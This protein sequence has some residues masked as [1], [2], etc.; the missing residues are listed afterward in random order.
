[1]LEIGCGCGRSALPMA[2][3]LTSGRYT[4]ID[5]SKE[6][7]RWCSENIAS[8]NPRFTFRHADV[9]NREY[10]PGGR[11]AAGNFTFPFPDRSFDFVYLTSVFTHMLPGDVAHYL[12]EIHRVLA[13]GGRTFLTFFLWNDESR[14]LSASGRA[15]PRFWHNTGEYLTVD[16]AVP[17][18]AT[19]FP[20]PFVIALLEEN[21]FTMKRGPLYGFWPGREG[22]A[23]GQDSI[24]A[25]K[26]P[27]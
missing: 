16:P 14:R 3:F 7:I 8:E 24:T 12:A 25:W 15:K 11:S 26:A 20:E 1:M 13:D 6:G 22:P 27:G 18:R 9:F 4:G 19:C 23:F 2:E 10:N 21:G 17:E 5:I